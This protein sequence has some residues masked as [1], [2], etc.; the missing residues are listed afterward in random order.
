MDAVRGR[1]QAGAW[2]RG[3]NQ[4]FRDSLWHKAMVVYIKVRVQDTVVRDPPFR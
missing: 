2:E 4:D 3:A 1:S